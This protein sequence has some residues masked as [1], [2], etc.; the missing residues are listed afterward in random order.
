M[1]HT[2]EQSPEEVLKR[3]RA[4]LQAQTAKERLSAI[5]QLQH[6]NFSS[7]AI[8]QT[9]EHLALHDN[10]KPVRQAA[11]QALNSPAHRYIRSRLSKLTRHERQ[12]VLNEIKAWTTGGLLQEDAASVL[13]TR[14]DFDIRTAEQA[15]TES[16]AVPSTPEP[17]S[18]KSDSSTSKHPPA[19][20]PTLTQTLLSETSIKIAL[21]LGAFFVI[22]AAAILAA[23]IEAARIPILLAATV[24]FA[25]GTVLTRK[26]LAQPS[27]ALFVVFS[28]LLPTDAN[29]L[30]DVLNLSEKANAAY[31]FAMLVGMAL[32]WGLGTWVYASRL[33]SMAASVALGI[34][35][36]RLAELLGGQGEIRLLLLSLA[37]LTSL[38]GA[39]LL[40]RWQGSRLGLP[41]FL[42]TQILQ[43]GLFVF[44][45][46][47]MAERTD[48]SLWFIATAFFWILS[49]AF[50][51]LSNLIFP[52]LLFP[53]FSVGALL[54]FPLTFMLAF[55]SLDA[56]WFA[57]GFAFFGLLQAAASEGT[58]LL[59]SE[60]VQK[61]GFPLLVFSTL[62]W[63]GA[64]I[65]G[66]VENVSWGF[67]ILTSMALV[68]SA[69]HLLRSRWY[70]WTTALLAG[71][72]AYFTFFALPFI[73][74]ANVFAGYQMLG[75]SLLLLIP[76]L[77]LILKPDPNQHKAWRWPRRALGGLFVLLNLLFL[78]DAKNENIIKAALCFGLYG[79]FFVIYALRFNRPALG[80]IATAFTP[81]TALYLFRG[82]EQSEWMLPVF[83]P[84]AIFYLLGYAL[85]QFEPLTGWSRTLRISGLGIASLLSLTAFGLQEPSGGWYVLATGLLFGV[86][87][88]KS[89]AGW[90]EP[91]LQIF[92]SLGLIMLL[93]DADVHRLYQLLTASLIWLTTDMGLN[94][95][96]AEKRPLRWVSRGIGGLLVFI[97]SIGA[98]VT[99]LDERTISI[100]CFAAY[101]LFFLGYALAYREARLAFGFTA[102]SALTMIYLLRPLDEFTWLL[103]LLALGTAFYIA[104]FLMRRKN[105][106]GRWSFV[107][108]SSGLGIGVIASVLAPAKSSLDAA[109]VPAIAAMMVTAEAFVR[110]NVWLGFPANALYLLAYFMIL[111][112][113]NIDQPQ[114]FSVGTALLG[115]LMHYLLT[116]TG[117]RT[118]TFITGMVSQFVLLGTTYIQ[119]V[120]TER[121]IFF[122]ALF[123]QAIVV[124]VYG[125]VV[126]S[127]SLVI[128][129]LI[130]IVLAVMTVLFGLLQGLGTIIMIG[131]T[132]IVLLMLGILAVMMRE[133]IKQI[134]DRF[135]NWTA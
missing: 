69:L 17:A 105:P 131:C 61:Y 32:I 98:A 76:D 8:L 89:R 65:A 135:S 48:I 59:K 100:I 64:V 107:L 86:E 31:W 121:L 9:L 128:T 39:H 71:S 129:P 20:R 77:F 132:G 15:Q 127:R 68:Y 78:L 49:A 55:D 80:Y 67:A 91:G 44:A 106:A 14:Y 99:H 110:R 10:S 19:E 38:G 34:S 96:F 42:L 29:V 122:S 124:I 58:R 62:H 117:S 92:T 40:N 18:T 24:L 111:G 115:L 84:A 6:V 5:K 33:F 36:L 21:Y 114:F 11:Q 16:A 126:R 63:L 108:W 123:F 26:R 101:T 93:N 88:F 75:I 12:I 134:G 52:F 81:L 102:F 37:C 116:R 1:E 35:A 118:A 23:A 103:P 4:S 56:F 2:E 95:F 94:A 90:I 85:A 54:L 43:P 133:R 53:W 120:S 28:F 97:T 104:G 72:S 45:L 30:A 83:L 60:E 22:A 119:F 51:A 87:L 66:F 46:V 13:A 7:P 112:T 50:Y 41:L 25:G 70:V 125:L 82:L 27:F 109:L 113:L 73:E 79:I 3:I 57:V 74:N 47:V 130:L